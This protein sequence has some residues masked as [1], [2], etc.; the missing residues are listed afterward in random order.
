MC[1]RKPTTPPCAYKPMEKLFD[2]TAVSW[3]DRPIGTSG[4]S[5]N[6][7]VI[8]SALSGSCKILL[9]RASAPA[10][11]VQLLDALPDTSSDALGH[12]AAALNTDAG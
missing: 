3:L 8:E 5:S 11:E 2:E 12:A 1:F 6:T 10:S 9:A 4:K 7:F